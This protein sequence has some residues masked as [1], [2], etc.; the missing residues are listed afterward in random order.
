[1][2]RTT[3][4]GLIYAIILGIAGA[5]IVHILVLVLLPSFSDRDAWSQLAAV[6]Q[7]H[8]FV[9]L[10]EDPATARLVRSAD[11]LF[12]AAACRFDLAQGVVHAK[13]PGRMPYWSI[14]VYNRSGQNIYSFN[15]RTA[16]DGTLDLV[17]LTPV[18]MLELKKSLPPEL[19]RSVIIELD[20]I[21]GIVVLR[22][23]VPDRTW[24]PLIADD[25]SGATCQVLP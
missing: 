8:Q 5:G 15:D 17:L 21:E 23:F 1:M 6:A 22:R 20:T 11:P 16:T 13:A 10:G 24:Q 7:P 18:Q 12:E 19:E 14:S 3:L 25:L 4:F 2:G 9:N